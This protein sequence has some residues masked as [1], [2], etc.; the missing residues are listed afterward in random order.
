MTTKDVEELK[1]VAS[2]GSGR[3]HADRLLSILKQRP[4]LFDAM[5]AVY[6]ANEES[7]SRRAVW[8][9]DLFT[10]ENPDLLLPL[11]DPIVEHLP[12]FEH[13][14]LKRHSLRMLARS[15]LPKENLG[16]LV[17]LCF[18]LLLSPAETPAVKVYA[19]EVLYNASMAEPDLRKE[20]IDSIEWRFREASAG[21][22]S[23]G[24][25]I[26]KRLYRD[27]SG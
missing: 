25:K 19:M 14:G 15:P 2:S 17:T 11:I 8:A 26:L 20:L 18:D 3:G 9:I 21:V 24:E 7:A 23:R 16:L 12:Q 1:K 13:D 22:R 10:E 5:V 4:E 27:I 6:F